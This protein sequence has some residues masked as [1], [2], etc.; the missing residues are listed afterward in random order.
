MKYFS[1]RYNKGKGLRPPDLYEYFVD[2]FWFKT[3]DLER[4][5]INEPLRGSHKADIVIVGGGYTGLSAAYNI[6]RK[7][8][9]KHIVLLEG[10]CCG[11]GASGRNGGF[12]VAEILLD[13]LHV[14]PEDIQDAVDVSFYGQKQIE[15]MID[16][17]GVDCDFEANGRLEAAIDDKQL[18][19]LKEYSEYLSGFGLET[20]FIEGQEL[21]NEIKSP[22]FK[23]GLKIPYGSSLNPAKLVREMKRVIEELGVEVRERSVVTRISPGKMHRVDTEFGDIQAPTLIIA[24]NAYSHKLG[25]FNDRVF[26]MIVHQ[27]ATEPLSQAQWD[28]IGWQ[29]RQGLSDMRSLYSYAI[30]SA[31]GRIVM[32]GL[33]FMYYD[34]DGLSAGNDKATTNKLTKNLFDFFPQLKGL[35]IDHA[36]S[37]TTAYTLSGRIPSVGV[38]GDDQNIYYGVGFS[39]GVPSSQT[40]GRMIADLMAGESNKFTNHYI[41]NKNIPYAGPKL[42]RGLFGK[43]YKW[44]KIKFG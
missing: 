30:P 26:P 1:S 28:S 25:F 37:G 14:K 19:E 34:F 7:F 32:G 39:N 43:A 42:L 36:W 10:A 3:I 6:K 21:Q 27:I 17:H 12:C 24:T 11:Y 13:D 44:K 40:A 41:V 29:N 38:M 35:N 15:M 33:E 16:E 23:A 2:N 22:F 4:I 5:K 9:E 8:P 20:T 18:Q 31:D